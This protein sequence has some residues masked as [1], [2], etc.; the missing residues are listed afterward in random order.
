MRDIGLLSRVVPLLQHDNVKLLTRAVGVSHARVALVSVHRQSFAL[1]VVHNMSSD[2]SSIASIRHEQALPMLIHLLKV[3]LLA[4]V[5]AAV[6]RLVLFGAARAF[7]HA[8]LR[9]RSSPSAAAQRA[10]FRTCPGSIYRA[11]SSG[12]LSCVRA[13]L[14]FRFRFKSI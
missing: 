2:S 13:A 4:R 7:S 6:A 12:R 1:Q 14:A 11:T 3:A 10:P 9:R 8:P 5:L